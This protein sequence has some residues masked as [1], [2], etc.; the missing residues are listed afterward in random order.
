MRTKR[1]KQAATAPPRSYYDLDE[2]RQKVTAGAVSI[3]GNALTDANDAF[4]W[5]Y[6]DILSALL[7]LRPKDFYKSEPS[8]YDPEVVL[9]FYKAFDLKGE[10]VY[11]HFY[12]NDKSGKLVVSSFKEI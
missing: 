8:I 7:T 4:G 3:R 2:V 5:N 9:D 12:I 11:T 1:K 10:K 6:D